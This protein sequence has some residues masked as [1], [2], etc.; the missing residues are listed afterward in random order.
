[1][2]AYVGDHLRVCSPADILKCSQKQGRCT[3]NITKIVCLPSENKLITSRERVT[4]L[5]R[6]VGCGLLYTCCAVTRWRLIFI[7]KLS[8]GPPAKGQMKNS[9]NG[10][11]MGKYHLLSI[12]IPCTLSAFIPLAEIA[13]S[14][15]F[16]QGV[17]TVL[18]GGGQASRLSAIHTTC[19]TTHE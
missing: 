8:I 6:G 16:C 18:P 9:Y 1:M 5:P 14:E 17:P 15:A 19:F 11:M 13:R 7:C 3:R 10:G 2:C 4:L 12:Y